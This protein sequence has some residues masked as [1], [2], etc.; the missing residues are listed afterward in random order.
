MQTKYQSA[1]KN[2]AVSTQIWCEENNEM[3]AYNAECW[4]RLEANLPALI[5]VY[6]FDAV[7]TAV[8][9]AK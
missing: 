1:A 9:S 8:N 6:S 4:A 7:I 5:K 3:D 2:I